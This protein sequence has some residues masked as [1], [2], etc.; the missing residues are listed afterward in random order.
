MLLK[1]NKNTWIQKLYFYSLL[2]E[3]LG[4]KLLIWQ[5]VKIF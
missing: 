4:L 1:S 5:N 3:L 2:A